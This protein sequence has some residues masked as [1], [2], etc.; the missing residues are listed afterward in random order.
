MSGYSSSFAKSYDGQGIEDGGLKQKA[1]IEP[2][3]L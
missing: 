3:D 2:P 1:N